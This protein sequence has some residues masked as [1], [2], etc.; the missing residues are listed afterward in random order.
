MPA[1]LEIF[2]STFKVQKSIGLFLQS[3]KYHIS[4]EIIAFLFH[5]IFSTKRENHSFLMK[6]K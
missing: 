5:F 6:R 4:L 3:L 1:I 2:F